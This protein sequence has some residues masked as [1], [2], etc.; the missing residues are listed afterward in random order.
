MPARMVASPKMCEVR[1]MVEASFVP[2]YA[3]HRRGDA[4]AKARGLESGGRGRYLRA[5]PMTRVVTVLCLLVASVARGDDGWRDRV[6]LILS[7]RVRGEFV[8]WFRPRPGTAAPGAERYDFFASQLRAGLSVVLPHAQLTLVAQDTRLANLPADASLL[9]L[10]GNLGPGAIYYASTKQRTQGEPFLKLGFL[11]LRRAGLAATVGRFEYR[12]G[13]E[14]V[15]GDPTLAALKRIRIAERLVGPFEFTHVTRSFDGA[16]LAYDRP[17]WNATVFGTRPTEGGF[18]VS[19]NKELDVTLAGA[20]LTLKRLPAGPPADARVF[21]LYYRDGRSRVLKVDDRPLPVRTA[22]HAPIA[23]HTAGGHALTVVDA[24]PGRMDILGWAA[25]QAGEWGVDDHLAWAWALETGYQLPALAA[26]PWLRVGYDWS[27][28]DGNPTD[29][30]H[31]TFFQLLPTARTYAQLPFYNL[32]NSGDAFAQ[33]LLTPH[34]N[35]SLRSDYHWLTVSDGRDLWYSGG[36]ATS[37]H[38]F[39]YAGS[40]AGGQHDLAQVVDLSAS[41]RVHPQVTVNGYYGHAFGGDVVRRTFAGSAADYGF[42]ELSYR[43]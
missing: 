22:D 23:I 5:G 26:A 16:R 27:S 6:S 20:A 1:L 41:V 30:H 3:R 4:A 9:P 25:V 12:D 36:G 39:G 34:R 18:E 42:V 17:A 15:P 38:V 28:G 14:T 8:D 37:N 40:P 32:M 10:A 33:I 13:L 35:L 29:G 31:R 19:A 7:E 24:G 43:R 2:L 21:Y 11:T